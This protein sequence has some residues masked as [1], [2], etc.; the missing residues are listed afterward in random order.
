M[1]ELTIGKML[2]ELRLPV[3]AL[4][5]EELSNSPEL[6]ELAPQQLLREVL[7]PQYIDTMNTRYET[8]LRLSKL[9]NKGA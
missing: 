7:E 4:R 2:D 9:L 3:S 5:W 8:N 6:G 1:S